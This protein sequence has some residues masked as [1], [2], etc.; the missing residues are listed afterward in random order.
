MK[1]MDLWG[2]FIHGLISCFGVILH[3]KIYEEYIMELFNDVV[4]DGL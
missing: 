1:P 3:V 4:N 2:K